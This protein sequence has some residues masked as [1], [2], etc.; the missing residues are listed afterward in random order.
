[1]RD[2]AG[3]VI[4]DLPY[5][6]SARASLLRGRERFWRLVEALAEAVLAAGTLD[7]KKNVNC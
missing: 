6:A 3:R 7:W 4:A 2:L 5:D 1:V